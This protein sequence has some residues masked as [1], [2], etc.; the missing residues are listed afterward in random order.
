[1]AFLPVTLLVLHL[2]QG[3][4]EQRNIKEKLD[5][6]GFTGIQRAKYQFKYFAGFFG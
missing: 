3:Q 1:V 5:L 2:N 6:L 4:A